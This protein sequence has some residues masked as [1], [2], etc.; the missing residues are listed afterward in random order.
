MALVMQVIWRGHLWI[1]PR[2]ETAKRNEYERTNVTIDTGRAGEPDLHSCTPGVFSTRYTTHTRRGAAE[3]GSAAEAGCAAN[4][5]GAPN[6][7]QW[8]CCDDG[9][10]QWFSQPAEAI[11]A[12]K[13]GRKG[14]AA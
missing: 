11:G 13:S 8:P 7:Q 9:A 1:K 5:T 12:A 2:L 14:E 4:S 6:C 3:A 10:G